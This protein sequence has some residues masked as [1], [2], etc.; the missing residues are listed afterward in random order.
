MA[1]KERIRQL[2]EKDRFLSLY[3][4]YVM[5]RDKLDTSIPEENAREALDDYI[6][7]RDDCERL[8]MHKFGGRVAKVEF[9]DTTSWT[10][11]HELH[12]VEA[13]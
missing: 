8:I 13:P 10:L 9:P 4:R 2:Q 7:G 1:E 5:A 12:M 3:V 6:E 11:P